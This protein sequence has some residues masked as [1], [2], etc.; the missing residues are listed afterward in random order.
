MTKPLT[1]PPEIVGQFDVLET[2]LGNLRVELMSLLSY[3]NDAGLFQQP[4]DVTPMEADLQSI[5]GMA[6]RL[7]LANH[8]VQEL[9]GFV[10]SA[11]AALAV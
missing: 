9:T 1:A 11:Y 10:A 2:S 8:G 6:R 7:E 4:V 5:S 3:L